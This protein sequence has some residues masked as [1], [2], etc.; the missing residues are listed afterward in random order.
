MENTLLSSSVTVKRYRQIEEDDDRAAAAA[1]VKERFEERY[2]APAL[3]ASIRHGFSMMAIACLTIESLQAFRLGLG[4]TKNNSGN[5]FAAFFAHHRAFAEFA[6]GTWFYDDI[7]CGILHVAEARGGWRILRSGPLIDKKTKAINATRFVRQLRRAVYA[8][9]A[10]LQHDEALWKLFKKKM[11]Q[12][13]KNCE[14]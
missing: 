8:Y 4:S 2:L 6:D 3:N 11:G 14:G 13:V 9:A 12:V 10:E 5:M 7:R 1:F